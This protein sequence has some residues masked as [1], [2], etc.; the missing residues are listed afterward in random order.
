MTMQCVECG[1]DLM[2][3]FTDHTE[4]LT[5]GRFE[6]TVQALSG[7][8]CP[9]CDNVEFD[10]D[11]AARY[12]AASDALV[13]QSRAHQAAEIR[14][15]RQRLGLTQR[16]AAAL[17]GGGHNAFSRYERGE[18]TPMPAVVHLFQILDRHPEHLDELRRLESE[19]IR[20]DFGTRAGGGAGVPAGR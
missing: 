13:Q 1:Y 14:R 19:R 17:T 9:D 11:S 7:W 12:A 18:A 20:I 4:T 15:I 5:H 3:P 16:Q 2:A 6:T 8:V 10:A